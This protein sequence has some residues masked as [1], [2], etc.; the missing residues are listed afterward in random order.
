M[1]GGSLKTTECRAREMGRGLAVSEALPSSCSVKKTK[2][3]QRQK[4]K[5]GKKINKIFEL[6]GT[7]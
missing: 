7:I 6:D 5:R 3:D 4:A 1:G 2:P